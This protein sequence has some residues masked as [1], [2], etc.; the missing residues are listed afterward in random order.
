MSGKN[1][2]DDKRVAWLII[3]RTPKLGVPAVRRLLE[4]FH[5]PADILTA[6]SDELRTLELKK[7]TIA[8]LKQP[9]WE[10]I[11][12]DLDWLDKQENHHLVTWQDSAYPVLLQQIPDPPLVLF[13]AGRPELL[14]SIQV[15]IV[16][17][18]NPGPN[19]RQI[20]HGFARELASLGFTIT[21]GLALGIDA[22]SHRG[23]LQESG[24]TVA[25]LGNGPDIIYPRRHGQLIREIISR[26][27][28]VTEFP[29]GTSPAGSNFPRRNRIISGLSAGVLVVEAALRSGSL[30]T[31]RL[32]ME[33]GREV[34]AIPGSIQN[35]LSRGCH[36]L[37]KQGAKLVESVR[38]I[39][40]DLGP[41]VLAG[42][43]LTRKDI[44][45]PDRGNDLDEDYRLL[46]DKLAYDPVSIDQLVN[47]TG[48]TADVVSS[49]LLILEVRGLVSA[50]PGGL[51][52]RTDP[53]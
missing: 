22:C 14:R 24:D 9:A 38:D 29:P 36:D 28:L 52:I 41:V 51:Y 25:V 30:I 21:S 2:S 45:E 40:E 11:H 39:I 7:Q 50:S 18:R 13:V 12:A 47:T 19:G 15:G 42:Q 43:T 32:A 16:G 48:L 26:G 34:F 4:T 1:L 44:P 49:M 8:Y 31:A 23:A 27:A 3:H 35:P 37:I 6:D 10:S 33:Q 53:R 5:T 20:A 17:S 46:L